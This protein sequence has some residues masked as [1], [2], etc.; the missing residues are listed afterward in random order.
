MPAMKRNLLLWLPLLLWTACLHGM[1][2]EAYPTAL[3]TM[4][5]IAAD[6]SEEETTAYEGSAPLRAIF[7]ANPE[8]LGSY[9]PHYEWR[10]VREGEEEP[11]LT[12]FEETTEYSFTTSGTTT[13][14]LHI[15]FVQGSDTIEYASDEPFVVIISESQLEMPN[16]FTP[17]GDGINDVYRAKEGYESI[18]E[19]HAAVFN[20]W[21]RKLYEWDDP[22]GGW[23]GTAGGSKAPDG[24]YYLVVNARGADGRQYK[25]KKTIN[26]LRGFTDNGTGTTTP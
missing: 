18:V 11:F 6:G 25:L 24:A 26:L 21:G 14:E 19:F 7:R 10:F 9:T 20:R 23:D 13:V 15:S 12:R 16:A 3:P 8:D 4:T 1:A 22:S 5:V 17:N 2:Q